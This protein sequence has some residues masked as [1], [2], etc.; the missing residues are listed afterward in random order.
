[1]ISEERMAEML[2]NSYRNFHV[3]GADY[4]C[5][6]RSPEH[7]C[8]IYFFDGD[9]RHLPEVVFPHD[10]RYAFDTH[11]LSGRLSN[12]LYERDPR[13]EV[14]NHFN[15]HTPLLGGS[16]FVFNSEERLF[17]KERRFYNA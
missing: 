14:F 16:G 2:E 11:I 5:L 3:K 9:V 13:G 15:W 12:S 4:L 17:E 8:K 1:M 10:H 6:R 7:T